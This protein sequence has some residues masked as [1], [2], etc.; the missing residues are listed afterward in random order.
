MSPRFLVLAALLAC[1]IAAA[2]EPGSDVRE[3]VQL[4]ADGSDF[5]R[6][7]ALGVRIHLRGGAFAEFLE[8]SLKRDDLATAGGSLAMD[9]GEVFGGEPGLAEIL[10]PEFGRQED[11]RLAYVV[12]LA[13]DLD[14][15]RALC[16]ELLG[17]ALGNGAATIPA[18]VGLCACRDGLVLDRLLAASKEAG[19][20][21]DAATSILANNAAAASRT[22][23]RE[24][25]A[26]KALPTPRRVAALRGLG[27]EGR[28]S[29][30]VL[31]VSLLHDP[32]PAVVEIALEVLVRDGSPSDPDR[33]G[34]LFTGGEPRFARST[35]V[36]LCM[37]EDPKAAAAALELARKNRAHGAEDLYLR[38]GASGLA[39]IREELAQEFEGE[40]DTKWKN[41][42]LAAIG[43]VGDEEALAFLV[44]HWDEE[45]LEDGRIEGIAWAMKRSPE[46]MDAALSLWLDRTCGDT[47]GLSGVEMAFVAGSPLGAEE[48]LVDGLLRQLTD[49]AGRPAIRRSLCRS[50]QLHCGAEFGTGE[51][52][53]A[54]WNAWWKKHRFAWQEGHRTR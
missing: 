22:R 7:R 33:L 9:A 4:S 21:G 52:A 13:F 18:R 31:A 40:T 42:L 51:D 8:E 41:V 11:E 46:S 32:D 25:A 3:F 26:D 2:E 28:A 20:K 24:I 15:A 44:R 54:A 36:L 29:D 35:A 6:A 49:L 39:E 5:E 45:A 27:G 53:P 19:P 10:K 14:L 34:E 37:L 30:A 47:I 17:L 16:G 38:A 12:K 23:L 50:L 1:R 48:A 43:A